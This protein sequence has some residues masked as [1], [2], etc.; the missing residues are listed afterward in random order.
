M[1]I[2][3]PGFLSA[4][5]CNPQLGAKLGMSFGSPRSQSSC[6]SFKTAIS[7][8]CSEEHTA[9]ARPCT[10]PLAKPPRR[11]PLRFYTVVGGP[12]STLGVWYGNWDKL[13]AEVLPTG[14]LFGSGCK[15][16]GFDS[17]DDADSF[18]LSKRSAPVP[19]F[20]L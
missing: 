3:E 12:P 7:R 1:L 9:S 2:I 11:K 4:C 17:R 8:E 16:R 20:E 6:A 5:P 14:K 18:W 10:T 13:C 19:F 15:L